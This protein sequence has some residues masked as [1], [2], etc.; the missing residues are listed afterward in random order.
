VRASLLKQAL[1]DAD[2]EVTIVSDLHK[3]LLRQV[4]DHPAD[5][6]IIDMESPDRDILEDV[7]TMQRLQPTPVVMFSENDDYRII[8]AA[9]KAG[10]SAYVVD[11]LN[12]AS[13]R[14]ILEVAI[15]RFDEYQKIRGELDDV[16]AQLTE[17]KVIE[18]AKGF[19]MQQKGL[20]EDTAYRTLRKMAMDQ[21]M[22]LADVA[23]NLLSVAELLTK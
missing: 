4:E 10:V 7:D 22:K 15:A 6:I 3:R 14:S 9:V 18:K 20:D 13:V 1:N 21:N 23:R 16:K 17:R 8:K 19:L 2:C 11:G 12:R 5:V